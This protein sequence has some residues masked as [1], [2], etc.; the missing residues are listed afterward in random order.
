MNAGEAHDWSPAP[1]PEAFP[2]HDIVMQARIRQMGVFRNL[3][4]QFSK[5][6]KRRPVSH[7]ENYVYRS[8]GITYLNF[9][10]NRMWGFHK[11][12]PCSR[13][14]ALRRDAGHTI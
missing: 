12:N 13:K 14:Q 11:R 5:F 4:N 6:K 8:Y 9:Q 10:K 2:Y 1:L 7:L 3:H